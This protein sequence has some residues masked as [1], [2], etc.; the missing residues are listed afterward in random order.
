MVLAL[1]TS[2]RK[3]FVGMTGIR[4][5]GMFRRCRPWVAATAMVALVGLPAGCDQVVRPS[6]D[7]ES[8]TYEVDAF[9]EIDTGD[10]WR[11]D[12]RIG[13]PQ[14][15][16]LESDDNVLD[17]TAV[18]V[19]QGRLS[20]LLKMDTL[21]PTVL[22]ATITVESLE[23]IAASGGARVEVAGLDTDSLALDLSGQARVTAQGRVEKLVIDLSS[24]ARVDGSELETGSVQ[25]SMSGGAQAD[26]QVRESVV[27][28]VS[29][30]AQLHVSGNPGEVDVDSSGGAAVDIR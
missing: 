8:R 2:T 15:V 3:G 20:I 14:S 13:S 21:R 9:D 17:A 16:V 10:G 29:G 11:V 28:S 18:D 27:G 12:V 7:V 1:M 6:R 26:L 30:S 24:G 5:A 25:V 19:S 4:F 22:Q 23:E